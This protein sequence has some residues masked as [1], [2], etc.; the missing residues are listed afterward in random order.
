[1][2]QKRLQKLLAEAGFGSRRHI[3]QLIADGC[4]VVNGQTAQLGAKADRDDDIC[5]SGVPVEHP[6][7]SPAR[8]LLYHKPLGEVVSRN[9]QKGRPTIFDHLPDLQY[10]RWIAVGRLD[11]ATSGLLVLTTDGQLAHRLAH[12]SSE[13]EREYLVH[14][15]GPVTSDTVQQLRRGVIL[16]DGM[17]RFNDLRLHRRGKGPNV[18][19]RVTVREGRNR[20]VRRLWQQQGT[21]VIHLIRRR[22]GE[23]CLPPELLP[24]TYCELEHTDLISLYNGVGLSL[25]RAEGTTKHVG[26]IDKMMLPKQSV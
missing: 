12:P 6:K 19:F 22:F 5:V 26:E 1:M 18:W 4:V 21:F 14:V 9:D 7:Q 11:I 15:K 25:A 2:I 20:L 8:V 24:G 23:C 10:G 16:E 17:A 13:I 3:E